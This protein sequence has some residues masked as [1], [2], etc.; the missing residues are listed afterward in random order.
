MVRCGSVNRGSP[1]SMMATQKPLRVRDP[2]RP[3]KILAAAAR[4]FA[5]QGFHPVSLADIGSEAGIVGSGVYRHFDNKLAVLV[6]LLDE[7]LAQLIGN[8]EKVLASDLPADEVLAQLVR[9]Q[10]EFCIDQRLAVQLYR[11]ELTA[12]DEEDARRLRRLQRRYN[13]EWVSA[14]LEVRS[15][16]TE[17]SAR[18]LV[19]SA[20]GAIQSTVMYDSGLA[21]ED[22]IA[23]VA[24]IA[25]RC[26]A[27]EV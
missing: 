5:A 22:Q 26:L 10:V 12:L 20:I 19:F 24:S 11:T 7:A 2:E 13:E 4:L 23:L 25:M 17:T 27:T 16:L 9:T 15:D 21:R 14:L 3:A 18:V 8:T 1:V 6:A